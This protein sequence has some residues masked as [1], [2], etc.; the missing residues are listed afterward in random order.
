M[1]PSGSLD[2]HRRRWHGLVLQR[3]ARMYARLGT[4]KS[5]NTGPVSLD[6]VPPAF[7]TA[8]RRSGSGRVIGPAASPANVL[9]FTASIH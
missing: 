4:R 5:S 3:H 6:T 8:G 7:S 2:Q 9:R 1:L